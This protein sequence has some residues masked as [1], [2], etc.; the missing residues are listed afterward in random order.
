[1]FINLLCVVCS[2]VTVLF[3]ALPGLPWLLSC[4]KILET[5]WWGVIWGLFV[6]GGIVREVWQWWGWLGEPP[7]GINSC[8]YYHWQAKPTGDCYVE[9][10]SVEAAERAC[11]QLHREYM[12][13]RY[14]EVFQCSASEVKTALTTGEWVECIVYII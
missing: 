10:N 12:G 4:M 8:W 11:H 6:V 5:W 3:V 13:K 1:V 2:V 9:M 14:I 7:R